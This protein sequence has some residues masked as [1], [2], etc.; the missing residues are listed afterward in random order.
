MTSADIA[1]TLLKTHEGLRLRAYQC[2][3]GKTTIGYGRNLDDR[4]ITQKEAEAMLSAD[5]A[6][7]VADLKSMPYWSG[8]SENR[9]AA[10]IDLRFNL[11]GQGFRGF[12]DMH[13]ALTEGRYHAAANDLLDSRYARQVGKRANDLAALLIEG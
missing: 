11:G 12:K 6:D 5:I 3:A 7:C 1:K 4:G 13:L 8:L 9:Q 10:L 2:T